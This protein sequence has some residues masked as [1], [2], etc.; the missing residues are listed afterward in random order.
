MIFSQW[1]FRPRP[2]QAACEVLQRRHDHAKLSH[3]AEVA[4]VLKSVG[5]V[6]VGWDLGEGKQR[7]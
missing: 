3:L 4:G 6:K 5:S 1:N 7:C 2:L